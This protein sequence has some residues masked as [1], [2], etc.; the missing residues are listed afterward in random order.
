LPK[1]GDIEA[2]KNKQKE[3][4]LMQVALARS[5]NLP[6]IIHCRDAH[7]D[8]LATLKE[9]KRKNKDFFPSDGR[10]WGVMHCF[11]GPEDLAWQYFNLGLLVSFTG[12]ITFSDKADALIRK[13]PLHKF[14]IETDCPFMTPAP[15]RGK[16]NEPLLVKRVAARIAEAKGLTVEKIG[17]ITSKNARELFGI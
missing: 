3:V 1:S 6:V 13:I 5:K 8:M 16:R 12:L 9:Y 11:Y 14:M 4:F 17:E 2:V 15:F 7:D 10:P